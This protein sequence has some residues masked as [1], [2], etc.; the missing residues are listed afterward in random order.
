MNIADKAKEI[1]E[2]DREKTYG[3]PGKNL[4]MIA[5]LWSAYLG[6]EMKATDV[7]S[8][9]CMLKIARLKNQPDHEDSK[10]DIIGYTLLHDKVGAEKEDNPKIKDALGK[11]P[12]PKGRG[13]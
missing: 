10:V 6:V 8:M 11:Q 9:M 1:V 4:T 2:G 3:D 13:F 7:C 12:R 5:G